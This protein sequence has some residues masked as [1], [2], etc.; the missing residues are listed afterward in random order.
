[1]S[2]KNVTINLGKTYELDIEDVPSVPKCTDIL[3]ETNGRNLYS[4]PNHEPVYESPLCLGVERDANT[5][6]RRESN[7]SKGGRAKT[8]DIYERAYDDTL[9]TGY[10]YVSNTE[11]VVPRLSQAY[12]A[13]DNHGREDEADRGHLYEE[14]FRNSRFSDNIVYDTNSPETL[15]R[16]GIRDTRSGRPSQH[17]YKNDSTR[18]QHASC[19]QIF[20]LLLSGLASGLAILALLV[21]SGSVKLRGKF[22]CLYFNAPLLNDFKNGAILIMD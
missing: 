13:Y 11:N 8:N 12:F 7:D 10:S 22:V 3:S 9:P 1:M 21:A 5:T 6:Q 15:R 17:S 16:E 18:K 20:T 4:N 19:I 2:G 14:S